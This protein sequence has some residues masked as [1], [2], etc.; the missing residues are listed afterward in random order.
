MPGV[1]ALSNK[2]IGHNDI[3]WIADGEAGTRTAGA[4]AAGTEVSFLLAS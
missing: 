3:G 1:F 2:L 4:A